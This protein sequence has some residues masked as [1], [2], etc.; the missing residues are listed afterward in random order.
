MNRFVTSIVLAA[1]TSVLVSGP[2]AAQRNQDDW[3]RQSRGNSKDGA[4]LTVPFSAPGTLND[5]PVDVAG[6]FTINRFAARDGKLFAIGTV[7]ATVPAATGAGSGVRIT[8]LAVP[9][10]SITGGET[11]SAGI[12]AQQVACGIL[13][14]ELGPLDLD[15]LGLVVHLD[16]VVLDISAEPGPGNLL[17]NLLCAIAGLLDGGSPLSGILNRLVDLLNDLIAAL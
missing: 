9:V 13:H 7:V 1:F 12:I 14:L 5:A 8:Q 16:R 3:Q 4:G 10:T 2:V 15:L 11:A 17:G 6:T